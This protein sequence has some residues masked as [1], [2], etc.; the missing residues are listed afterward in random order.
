MRPQYRPSWA[1]NPSVASLTLEPLPAGF[2]RQLVMGRLGTSRLPDAL[3]RVVTDRAEGNPLFA[4]EIATFLTERGALRVAGDQ[5]RFDEDVVAF[6]LP[7]SV[8]GLLTARVDQLAPRQRALLQAASVIGRK[9]EAHLVAAVT[10]DRRNLPTALTDMEALDLVR[11]LGGGEYEFKHVLVR[12][13][14]YQSLLS[15]PRAELHLEIAEEIE[16]RSG[17]R[18]TEVA[19]SLAHHYCRTDRAA[20]AFAYLSMAGTKCLSVY[21]LD[22]AAVHFTGALALIDRDPKCASDDQVAEFLASYTLLLS[23]SAKFRLLIEVLE[24]HLARIDRLGD[25][26]SVVLIR[27][28]Y[29]LAL[30]WNVQYRKAAIRQ[31][32]TSLVA[33]RL[34]DS[35]SKAYAMAGEIFVSTVFSPKP[36]PEF[37]KLKSKAIRAISE[38]NDA[39]IQGMTLVAIGLDEIH[40]GRMSEARESARKL[41]ELGQSLGDPRSIGLSL[42]LLT[43]IALNFDSYA[44]ALEYS[45]QSLAVAITPFDRLNAAGGK[46]SALVLLRR[47]EE[48]EILLEEVSRRCVADGNLFLLT[49]G[50]EPFL[51]LF[52]IIKG[53][54]ASGIRLFEQ[55]IVKREEEGYFT[56]ADLFRFYLCEVYLQIIAGKEK[57]SIGTLIRNLPVIA[58]LKFG[59]SRRILALTTRL[60]D[61]PQFLSSG[62]HVGRGEMI[63]GLLYQ[64]KKKHTLALQHLTEARRILS[65][66]GQTPILARVETALAELGQ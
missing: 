21:S 60:F 5:V 4:E 47:M 32:E 59:A 15:E 53:D 50:V 36:L 26:P 31:R 44:E 49:A 34:G 62:H 48:A 41:M 19:E 40:V 33:D 63:L 18:L 11:P 39:Y 30:I 56:N 46:A 58:K 66:F 28:Q 29:V 45:E 8:Q 13:A 16:R 10:G 17:N 2:I 38:T 52:K 1:A 22:E 12:D 20:K 23:M 65:Q 43:W 42:S 35:K 14:L 54:I 6:A 55:L 61:N 3:G 51:A 64:I 24:R 27:H 57:P 7:S 37:E 9:F 25:N